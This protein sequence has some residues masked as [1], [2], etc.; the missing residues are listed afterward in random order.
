MPDPVHLFVREDRNFSLS[1]WI[2]CL[3]RT[4][5]VALKSPHLWQP[6]FF[7]HILWSDESYAE[8][9]NYV[10]RNPVRAGRVKAADD[11]LYQGEIVVIDRA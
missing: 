9:W 1:T 10:R 5:F 6:A 3:K 2:G 11:W 7:D 8:K 4:M